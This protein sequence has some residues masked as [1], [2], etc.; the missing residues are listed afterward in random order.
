MNEFIGK[1]CPF[2]KTAIQPGEDMKVCHACGMPHHQNCWEENKGCTTFG[3][4]EQQ[5]DRHSNSTQ[6]PPPSAPPTYLSGGSHTQSQSVREII[7]E[8][9]SDRMVVIPIIFAL[10]GVVLLLVGIF[11]P[12]PSREFSFYS[13][14]EYVGGDAYNASI[15]AAIRGGEIA[16][17]KAAKAI[18][19]CSGLILAAISMFRIKTYKMK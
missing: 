11:Y 19:I 10:I 1:T 17:A 15:E 6:S 13:I 14:K 3:C 5:I 2:C 8:A 12:V 16:G 18:F 9:E 4:A 7:A